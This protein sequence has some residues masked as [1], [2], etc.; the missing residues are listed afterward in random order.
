MRIV[1]FSVERILPTSFHED[2][3]ISSGIFLETI[4]RVCHKSEGR[5]APGSHVRFLHMLMDKGHWSV[6][7]HVRL[8]T[9]TFQRKLTPLNRALSAYVP[10]S[11]G[12][13]AECVHCTN[14]DGDAWLSRMADSPTKHYTRT[15]SIDTTDTITLKIVT[16]RGI[17]HQ[18]VRHRSGF[19]F[20]QESTRYVP[21][22]VSV[23]YCLPTDLAGNFIGQAR[24]LCEDNELAYHRMLAETTPEIARGALNHWLAST[25]YVTAPV[26]R[27]RH[28]MSQR[29]KHGQHEHKLI[30]AYLA[31]IMPGK[32]G[33]GT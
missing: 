21:Y 33:R 27:W 22:E 10:S 5:M 11:N 26:N 19:S 14:E 1:P 7:E 16:N 9:G 24:A 29:K 12:G 17:T 32:F 8:R 23:D 31:K 20:T 3:A 15:V 18:L 25:I 13:A 2:P 28:Y 4:G 6:F 30:C